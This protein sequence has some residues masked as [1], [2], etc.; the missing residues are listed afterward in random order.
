[1]SCAIS[2]LYLCRNDNTI[3]LPLKLRS[4]SKA[5]ID[6]SV[7]LSAMET[8]MQ[9]MNIDPG[10]YMIGTIHGTFCTSVSSD[11]RIVNPNTPCISHHRAYNEL[12]M[13]CTPMGRLLLL[14]F[15]K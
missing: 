11:H 13:M 14:E 7:D 1:M 10:R 12:D 9:R 2:Y 3:D 8:R 6:Y 4:D 5:H 15:C